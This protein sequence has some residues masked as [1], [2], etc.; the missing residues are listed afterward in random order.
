MN[1]EQHDKAVKLFE[2]VQIC[3]RNK[4]NAEKSLDCAEDYLTNAENQYRDYLKSLVGIG[5]YIAQEEGN[6][7]QVQ[8]KTKRKRRTKAEIETEKAKLSFGNVRTPQV[9]VEIKN[10]QA[11]DIAP[12]P[13]YRLEELFERH[14]WSSDQRREFVKAHLGFTDV[15]KIEEF[16]KEI[17]HGINK[18]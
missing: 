13:H 10:T 16:Q 18:S 3:M 9:Q 2:I 15:Q 14:N 8:T 5:E 12:E 6:E 1:Q 7:P 4:A 11:I 17:I